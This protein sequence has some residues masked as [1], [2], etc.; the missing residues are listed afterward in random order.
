MRILRAS[1][2]KQSLWTLYTVCGLVTGGDIVVQVPKEN[3]IE[4][5]FIPENMVRYGTEDFLDDM[6]LGALSQALG[7]EVAMVPVRGEALAE[8]VA[9]R[10]I[11]G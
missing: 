10:L 3:E 9:Q 1:H 7:A 5:Y 11:G 8:A 6:T 4:T 2:Q